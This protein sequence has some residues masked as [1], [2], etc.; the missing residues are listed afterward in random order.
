MER[1]S[2]KTSDLPKTEAQS[3][4]VFVMDSVQGSANFE[5]ITS[6]VWVKILIVSSIVVLAALG[7]FLNWWG[8]GEAVFGAIVPIT[9]FGFDELR[10]SRFSGKAGTT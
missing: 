9:I 1:E 2:V 3:L 6:M 4:V 8:L 10:S 5:K 7:T